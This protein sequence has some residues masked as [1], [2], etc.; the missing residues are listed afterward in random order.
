MINFTRKDGPRLD[1]GCFLWGDRSRCGVGGAVPAEAAVIIHD[2]PDITLGSGQFAAFNVVTGATFNTN[3]SVGQFLLSVYSSSFFSTE[4][5]TLTPLASGGDQVGGDG[6]LVFRLIA[7]DTIPAELGFSL[8]MFR[9]CSTAPLRA[10]P[11]A[12]GPTRAVCAAAS[13]RSVSSSTA[14]SISAGPISA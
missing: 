7:G 2:I 3:S 5:V 12:S 14:K 6:H 4:S 10:S 9:N 11:L 1:T 13:P 8:R